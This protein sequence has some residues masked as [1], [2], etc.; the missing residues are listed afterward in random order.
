MADGKDLKIFISGNH[1]IDVTLGFPS[2][3][4]FMGTKPTSLGSGKKAI[5]SLECIGSNE[6]D[7][8]AAWGVQQ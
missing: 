5:L 6:I 3:W 2:G 1:S 8:Y 4:A 7:V